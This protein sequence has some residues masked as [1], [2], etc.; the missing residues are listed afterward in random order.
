MDWLLLLAS[1]GCLFIGI[2]FFIFWIGINTM[3]CTPNEGEWFSSHSNIIMMMSV[4]F[5]AISTYGFSKICE[6]I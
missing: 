4:L 6:L 5:I 1:F 2:F 3:V